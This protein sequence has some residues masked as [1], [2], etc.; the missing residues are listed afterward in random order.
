LDSDY[1]FEEDSLLGEG[2][3]GLVKKAKSLK[4]G[5]E[6]AIKLIDNIQTSKYYCRKVL[7]EIIILRKLSDIK[8]NIFTT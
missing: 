2:S 3:F 4:T 1:E 7:R 6:V 5:Q 8:E